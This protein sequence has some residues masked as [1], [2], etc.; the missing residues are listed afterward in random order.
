MVKK[1][2]N[3]GQ[4]SKANG[5]ICP[6][7]SGC[8]VGQPI[9]AENAPT[10]AVKVICS[11]ASNG[12]CEETPLIHEE[13]CDEW[14][15]LLLRTYKALGN[16]AR[17]DSRME[18]YCAIS[19]NHLWGSI[20]YGKIT[21][22]CKC[23][24]GGFLRKILEIKM[25]IADDVEGVDK[26]NKIVKPVKKAKKELPRLAINTK[27]SPYV[28]S[29]SF[30]RYN[31]LQSREDRKSAEQIVPG[32]YETDDGQNK[33]IIRQVDTTVRVPS[34]TPHPSTTENVIL[35]EEDLYEACITFFENFSGDKHE[36]NRFVNNVLSKSS[37]VVLNFLAEKQTIWRW[38]D[39]RRSIWGLNFDFITI[40]EELADEDDVENAAAHYRIARENVNSHFEMTE[41]PSQRKILQPV[42]YPLEN[43]VGAIERFCAFDQ[44]VRDMFAYRESL[45]H[46]EALI[47]LM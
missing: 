3:E 19:M 11:N 46:V 44:N 40:G 41:S 47:N 10:N 2:Q 34:P 37:E 43:Y 35:E 9:E 14:E 25:P 31:I 29:S 5:C 21:P 1:K 28:N 20:A 12:K 23:P 18:R 4:P 38:L 17:K 22:F 24:C 30:N 13:C 32:L 42:K 39:E 16:R 6:I 45:L 15:T 33:N 7:P 8:R 36:L 27:K 26:K